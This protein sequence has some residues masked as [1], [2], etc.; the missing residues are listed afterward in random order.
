M[1]KF[2]AAAENGATLLLIYLLDTVNKMSFIFL[3]S[4]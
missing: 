4:L 2:A 3:P 1:A